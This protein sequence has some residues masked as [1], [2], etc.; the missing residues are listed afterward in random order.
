MSREMNTENTRWTAKHKS[1]LILDIIQGKTTVA[2]ASRKF[3]LT[4]SEL[5]GWVE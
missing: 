2:E 5:A 3:D 1:A 4:L